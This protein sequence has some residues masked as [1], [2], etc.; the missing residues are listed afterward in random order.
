MKLR[1]LR[2]LPL[3]AP[4]PEGYAIF[5]ATD[6][7]EWHP[8]MRVVAALIVAGTGFWGVQVMN[9]MAE[10]NATL[11][12]GESTETPP[13]PTWKS[14]AVLAVWFVGVTLLTVFLDVTPILRTLT[15]LGLV[16]IGF[17]AAY[18]FNLSNLHET[19]VQ[20]RV[21]YRQKTDREKQEKRKS[22]EDER[23]ERKAHRQAV[24]TKSKEIATRLQGQG[25]AVQ[26]KKG[27]KVSDAMLLL[28]WTIDPTLSSGDMAEKLMQEGKVEKISR[29][30]IDDRLK[31]MIHSGLVIRLGDGRVVEVIQESVRVDGTGS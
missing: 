21:A 18:L 7:L 11:R 23:K 20:E 8:I 2:Y 19:R 24:A 14:I 22:N 6:I 26:P 12:K 4:A 5:L 10:F 28:E 1:L 15:P 3:L 27:A 30:A 31:K 16:V 25:R 9:D 13:L 17:S 29:Q